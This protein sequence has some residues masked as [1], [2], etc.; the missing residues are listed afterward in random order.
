MIYFGDAAAAPFF[1]FG[2]FSQ[3]FNCME[4]SFFETF[5]FQKICFSVFRR[6]ICYGF[7]TTRGR[8]AKFSV[9]LIV[10][11]TLSNALAWNVEQ[12]MGAHMS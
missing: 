6:K 8:V 5:V 12:C 1:K 9:E 11:V 7:K 3:H 10:W 4:K 2:I